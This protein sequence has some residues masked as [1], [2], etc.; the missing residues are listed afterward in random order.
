MSANR[1]PFIPSVRTFIN[2]T[3]IPVIAPVG[4]GH[5]GESFNINADTVAWCRW[6]APC[7]ERLILLTDVEGVLVSEGKLIPS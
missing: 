5:H 2:P 4:V 7:S 6:P 3:F 1:K